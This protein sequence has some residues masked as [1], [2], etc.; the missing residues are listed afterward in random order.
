MIKQIL[1]PLSVYS[2][3][4]YD[5]AFILINHLKIKYGDT[6]VINQYYKQIVR[7]DFELEDLFYLVNTIVGSNG[8]VLISPYYKSDEL[9]YSNYMQFALFFGKKEKIVNKIIK[10][11]KPQSDYE[12][13]SREH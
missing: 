2:F 6:V 1:N 5:I 7:C 11:G 3:K 8:K 13:P 12:L 4:L 9:R 10:I